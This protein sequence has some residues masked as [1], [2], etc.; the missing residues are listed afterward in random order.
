MGVPKE[1]VILWDGRPMI[2][3][4]MEPLQSLCDKVVIVGKCNGYRLPQDTSV[5]QMDDLHPGE[6]PLAGIEAV[7]KSGIDTQYLV[8]SCDQPLL[9]RSL[10]QRLV[11]GAIQELRFFQGPNGEPL[12]PFPGHFP[13]SFL[14]AVQQAL[15]QGQRSVRQL[16][17]HWPVTWLPLD[18]AELSSLRS[19]NTPEELRCLGTGV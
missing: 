9:T 8:V 17:Q 15:Q 14:P 2:E 1:G 19:V 4:V 10:L 5:F 6:G 12:D 13:I 3:H 11:A 18:E 16:I 7:L